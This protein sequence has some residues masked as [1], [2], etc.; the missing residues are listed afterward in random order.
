MKSED[1][2]KLYKLLSDKKQKE[3][4]KKADGKNVDFN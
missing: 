1:Q 2:K 4:L 3:C